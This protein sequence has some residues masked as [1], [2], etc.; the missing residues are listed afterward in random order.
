MYLKSKLFYF[1]Y[2]ILNYVYFFFY[3]TEY[4]QKG[5]MKS[6]DVYLDKISAVYCQH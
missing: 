6:S 3:I 2:Y 5:N 1:K 4:L